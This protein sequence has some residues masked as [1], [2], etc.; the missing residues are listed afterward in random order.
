MIQ[1][2]CKKLWGGRVSVRDCVVK[3][4]EKTG[5]VIQIEFEGQFMRVN[6]DTPYTTDERHHIALRTDKYIK[7]G[8]TYKLLD[9]VWNPELKKQEEFTTD[10]R[11]KL[12]EAWKKIQ[13]II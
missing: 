7:K 8:L 12:L 5:Q 2:S 13:K 6:K 10:G 3:Y 1:Y 11:A 9:Y 4:A